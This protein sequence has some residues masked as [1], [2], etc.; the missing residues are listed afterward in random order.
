MSKQ[1]N[2]ISAS[3]RAIKLL[4]SSTRINLSN[5]RDNPGA[6]TQGRRVL[7]K[8]NKAGQSHK[9]LQSA[10]KPP[11][12]WIYGDFYRPWH[13]IWSGEPYNKD[14]HLRREYPPLSLLE[15]Q[16]LIDLGWIDTSLPV[17]LTTLCNTRLYRC[18]P[19]LRQF[20]VNLTEEG[21]DNFK[22]RVN[23][24]VQWT[25]EVAIAAVE[26]NGGIITMAY[27]DP[28]SL[29][30]LTDPIRFFQQG[31]P[32]PK[33][34]YPPLG[35]MKQYMDPKNRGYLAD[36][37]KIKEAR[38]ETMQK[39]GFTLETDVEMDSE[40]AIQKTPLQ[41]FYGLHPGWV[42]SLTDES[43][44]KPKDCDLVHYYSS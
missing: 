27:F 39:Y 30:A 35:L 31:V 12:G 2:A 34:A 23:I 25:N 1:F 3:E 19:S 24:E 36:P 5:I 16:R 22:A 28:L 21:A 4:Q 6:R 15:L 7:S 42:I 20:G 8:H 11:L 29:E 44:L 33:R 37:K 10:A 9:E 40:F 32:I 26:R 13:R 17:D 38:I 43:V 18:D 41:I 14:I